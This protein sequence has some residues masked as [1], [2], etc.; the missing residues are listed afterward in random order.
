M[1]SLSAAVPGTWS[2]G[3]GIHLMEGSG[4][5][6]AWGCDTFGDRGDHIPVLRWVDPVCMSGIYPPSSSHLPPC[7]SLWGWTPPPSCGC[8]LV[9]FLHCDCHSEPQGL[10]LG[11]APLLVCIPQFRGWT[12]P[13]PLGL[14]VPLCWW[15]YLGGLFYAGSAFLAMVS[16]PPSPSCTKWFACLS[17]N[18]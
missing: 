15:L 18:S 2:V 4:S 13:Y 17:P 6:V 5:T 9:F 8:P 11:L 12:F 10:Y 16:F 7:L 3:A 1:K 14:L